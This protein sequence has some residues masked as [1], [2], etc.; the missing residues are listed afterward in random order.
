MDRALLSPVIVSDVTG[1]KVSRVHGAMSFGYLDASQAATR[2]CTRK[3]EVENR[4]F[5]PLVYKVTPTLRYQDDKDTGAVTMTVS[6]STIVVHP[7]GKTQVNVK[8]TVDGTKL[9]NNQMNS[10][11]LGN[12]IGPLTANEYDGYVVFQGH[13]HQV[14]M[15]WHILPRKSADVVA[16]L[17]GGHL[18]PVDPLE[19][20]GLRAAREQGCR[21]CADLRVLAA[22]HRSGYAAWRAWRPGAES[23]D[24]RRGGQHLPDSG[25]AGLQRESRTSSGSS[26]STCTSARPRQ[27]ARS[28][29]STST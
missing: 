29:K 24:S 27:W 16:K 18:P 20:R 10:G 3:L 28:T 8:L 11:S 26:C 21:R 25:G 19:W 13:H 4:S 2:S 12:A 5:F 14:T 17:P 22:R 7:F 15:P 9:R 23:D 6:P 1:D